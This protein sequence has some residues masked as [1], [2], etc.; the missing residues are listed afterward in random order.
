MAVL[1][2][3]VLIGAASC[4]LARGTPPDFIPPSSTVVLSGVP[5]YPDDQHQ[6][7]PASL[8]GLLNFYGAGVTV[9]EI[10]REI[11]RPG[12]KGSVSLDLVL[13]ARNRG[14]TAEWFQG[15]VRDL[16]ASVDAGQ[17]LLVMVD[18]GLGPVRQGHYMIV[19]GY[20]PEGLVAH[21]GEDPAQTFGW[22]NFLAYWERTGRWTMKVAR[23]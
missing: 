5:F 16:T 23:R 7:G 17:P 13:Y 1:G 2:L 14:F 22:A 15:R 11:Y 12:L 4:S 6:C 9:D 10:G 21:S 3:I 19:V 18:Y 8:A 20:R